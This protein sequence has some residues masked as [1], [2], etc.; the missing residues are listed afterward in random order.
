MTKIGFSLQAEYGRPIVQVT[1]LLKASGFTA[2]SPVWSPDLD[3][4]SISESLVEHNMT[5]QSLHAPSGNFHA[6]E[7]RRSGIC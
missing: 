7:A 6:V 4:E 5:F 3:L 1:P 2:V